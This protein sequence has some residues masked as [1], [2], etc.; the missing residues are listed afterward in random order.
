MRK[1][2]LI[3]AAC[4]LLAYPVF[5]ETVGEKTG[6]NSTLGIAPTTNDF[7]QEAA[8]SDMFEVQSSTI[9]SAKLSGPGERLRRSDDYGSHEDNG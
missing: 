5:A 9:A 2:V 4:T 8:V 1:M 7:V 6:I 3:T